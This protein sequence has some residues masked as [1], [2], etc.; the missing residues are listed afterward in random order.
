M[1]RWDPCWLTEAARAEQQMGP[2]DPGDPED[3]HQRQVS[4]AGPRGAAGSRRLGGPERQRK[5][6]FSDNLIPLPK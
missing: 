1:N 6:H 3:R 4:P 5:C 2:G